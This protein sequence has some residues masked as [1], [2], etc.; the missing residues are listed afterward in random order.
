MLTGATATRAE[1]LLARSGGS[2]L[3]LPGVRRATRLAVG[4]TALAGLRSEAGAAR[5][6]GFPLGESRAVTLELRRFAPVGLHTRVDVIESDGPR[7]IAMPD[8]AYFTG[9]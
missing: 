8:A 4:R 9:A 3:E 1:P 5:V 7:R 2:P 6:E